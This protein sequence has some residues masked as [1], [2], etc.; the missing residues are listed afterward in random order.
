MK[1]ALFLSGG[2]DGH[3]PDKIVQLFSDD[4]A[5]RGFTCEI[6]RSLDPLA[7]G[8]RL[9]TYD[10]I[11]LCWTMGQLSKE[12]TEGLTGAVRDGVAFA[13]VHGGAGDAF[14]GNL[15]FEWLVGGHFVGHPHVGDYTVR[16]ADPDNPITA[17]LPQTFP[18]QSE[19]Y[20]MMMDPA[21]HVLADSLYL[22]DGRSSSMPVA[23]TKTWGKG[24]VFYCSLGHDPEEFNRYPHARALT[25][26]G[27]LWSTRS[28]S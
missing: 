7:D 23:W 20:Y 6:E 25:L 10:L 27:I 24:R 18:Y 17:G 16:I 11:F 28:L 15:D 14:R 1:K 13:G 8:A 9:R 2:W 3:K 4:L 22:H 5:A 12:Q 26:N 21:V 19:Q